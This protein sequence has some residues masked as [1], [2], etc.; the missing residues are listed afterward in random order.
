MTKEIS[1]LINQR[2]RQILVHSV[3]YYNYND[4][5]ISDDKWIHYAKELGNLQKQYPE[6]AAKCVYH[7]AFVN[8][9]CSS[10]YG[11]PLDDPWANWKAE[12]LLYLRNRKE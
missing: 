7:E 8:F 3:I 12:R 4:S 9:D 1:E 6:I 11:L 5:I 10:G 2:R